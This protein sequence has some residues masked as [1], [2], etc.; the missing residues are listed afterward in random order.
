MIANNYLIIDLT[1]AIERGDIV[2]AF[3]LIKTHF[4]ALAAYDLISNSIPPLTDPLATDLQD[5]LVRLRCQRFVEIIRTSSS[6]LEAIRYAQSHLKPTNSIAKERVKEV[7]ALIAYVDP[8]QSQSSYLLSQQRRDD[9]AAQ[10]NHAVLGK[11]FF[12]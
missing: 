2:L 10:V 4:P 1:K 11:T 8:H 3:E 9:L 5:I 6:T 12:F 7:T